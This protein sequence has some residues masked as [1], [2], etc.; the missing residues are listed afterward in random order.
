MLAFTAGLADIAELE[1]GVADDL[2]ACDPCTGDRPERRALFPLV[3]GFKMGVN[4]GTWSRWQPAMA[5]GFRTSAGGRELA[6]NASTAKVSEAF[7]A[8]GMDLGYGVKLH[9]GA[10]LWATRHRDP[11]GAVLELSASTKT[12]R[13]FAAFEYTPPVTPRT[14]LLGDVAWIPELE[15]TGARLR[16]IGGW[17]AR[18]QALSW[19]SIE[20]EVRH[21]EGDGLSGSTVV[22]R[23]NGVFGI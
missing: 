17:G 1:L 4:Q 11:S 7:L 8:L 10:A 2:A 12:L 9:G 13:P 16:W 22:V 23:L 20:L 18:Y 15:P 14:T 6:W 21:R 3:A 5:L 19:G